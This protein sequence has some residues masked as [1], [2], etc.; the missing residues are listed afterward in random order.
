MLNVTIIFH[1]DTNVT[2]G[3][4]DDTTSVCDYS[5]SLNAD[6]HLRKLKLS[7][8]RL[9]VLCLHWYWVWISAWVFVFQAFK[10]TMA[11]CQGDVDEAALF[12]K[13]TKNQDE[14]CVVW[15]ELHIFY[16]SEYLLWL[17]QF[18]CLN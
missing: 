18:K 7:L 17:L 3:F 11:L 9:N 5:C 10:K 14:L 6:V 8:V 4:T 2:L 12:A 1:T 15:F 13:V 16:R